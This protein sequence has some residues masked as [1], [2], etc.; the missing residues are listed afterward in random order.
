MSGGV[1]DYNLSVH[2]SPKERV[3]TA[4]LTAPACLSPHAEPGGVFSCPPGQ[5]EGSRM[6]EPQLPAHA[7]KLSAKTRFPSR[8]RAG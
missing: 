6:V 3:L 4:A 7:G 2:T 8:V 1:W 5:E